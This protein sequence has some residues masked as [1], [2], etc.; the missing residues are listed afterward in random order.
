MQ[1]EED[2]LK[3]KLEKA[4]GEAPAKKP[5]AAKKPKAAAEK[6]EE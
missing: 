2:K 4:T 3:A 5:R 6:K 1:K